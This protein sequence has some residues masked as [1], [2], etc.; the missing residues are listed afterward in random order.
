MSLFNI[1]NVDIHLTILMS[2]YGQES[3]ITISLLLCKIAIHKISTGSKFQW[4]VIM[5]RALLADHLIQ[6]GM[7]INLHRNVVLTKFTQ[8]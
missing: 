6:A 8:I 7:D 3:N 5:L 1:S 4:Y 2:T